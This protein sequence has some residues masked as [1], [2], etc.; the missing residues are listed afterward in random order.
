MT[1]SFRALGLSDARI[2]QLE[3][4]GFEAP[5]AIQAEA[6]PHLITG[7]DVVGQAQTGTGKTAAFGLPIL[8]RVDSSNKAVQALILTPTRELAMQVAQAI[9]QFNVDRRLFVLTVYGGQSIDQQISRLQRGAQVLVGTPG[10]VLDLLKRRELHLDQLGCLVL[11]EADEML[12]MGFL[13]DVE[14]ILKQT[15]STRQLAF[16]SATLPPSIQSL[17]K[18]FLK[19]PVTVSVKATEETQLNINQVAY[20]VPRGWTKAQALLPILELER[21]ASA[22]IFVRTR[23]TAAE[24]TQQL[25]GGGHSVDEYHGDLSQAQ[26][27]RM[28]QRFKNHQVKLIVA[29]D[30]AA[31]GIHVDNLTHVINFDLPDSVENYVHR[32]GRTGRAGNAGTAMSII[33]NFDRRKLR[34]IEYHTKQTLEFR[35]VPTRAQIEAQQLEQLK[36]IVMTSLSGERV[37]SFLPIVAELSEQYEPHMVAAAALQMLY[38]RNRPEWLDHMQD[39]SSDDYDS[40]GGGGGGS[41]RD[42]GGGG[43]GRGGYRGNGGGGGGGYRGNNSG[44][45]RGGYRG[46]SSGG[47]G[48]GSTPRPERRD[49]DYRPRRRIETPTST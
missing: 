4:M 17:V 31:R 13:D 47:G 14:D 30:I 45:G 40:R 42:G 21:P 41:Y 5:T 48:G 36:A 3:Q 18:R 1:V 46:N 9:K 12:S 43:G 44:G 2:E 11:D 34:D 49:G 20:S 19:D 35:N 25:Q 26:R 10:R 15:P 27:E 22:I 7:R 16:F 8:E 23:R 29:T 28:M 37:A 32:I 39:S 6:I 24:L 38:D 33:Q